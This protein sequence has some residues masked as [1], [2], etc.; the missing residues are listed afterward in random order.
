MLA[1]SLGTI[2]QY[3]DEAI[4]RFQKAIELDPWKVPVYI[5]FAE[6]LEEMQFPERAYV[7]YSKLLEVS[8][9]TPGVQV[10]K[11]YYALVRK[12]H[13]VNHMGNRE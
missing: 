6:L 7:V 1:R 2:P 13:P 5:Q 11:N 12:F 9:D 8:S 4:E 10:K 3:Q